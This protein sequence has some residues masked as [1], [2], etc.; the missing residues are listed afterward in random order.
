MLKVLLAVLA[1]ALLAVPPPAHA[2]LQVSSSVDGG[3]VVFAR[4]NQTTSTC[5]SPV[6]GPCQLPDTDP[7]LGSLIIN[8]YTAA[9]GDLSVLISVQTADV[10]TGSGFNRLDSTGTQVTNNSTTTSHTFVVAIGA[11][12]FSGPAVTATTTGAGQWST[13]SN[14]AAFGGSNI[15]MRWYDD[16]NNVQGAIL[17]SILQP[18]ILLDTFADVAGPANPDSFSHTGGPFPVNDGSLFGMTLE[19]DGS[20]G[21]GV[22][23]TGREMTEL[24]PRSV[25]PNPLSLLLLGTG[26]L[27]VRKLGG[28]R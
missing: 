26:L 7:A 21:P 13:L 16:P 22:R 4:D 1:F 24:K 18:G 17:A 25:V 14:P 10:A 8:S 6:V 23:L 28:T 19:F 3:G 5:G 11:T 15:T 27:F 9:G 12:D 2:I 20:I